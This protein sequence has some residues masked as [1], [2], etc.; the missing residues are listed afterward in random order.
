MKEEQH[1]HQKFAEVET[2]S[3][4]II[5]GQSYTECKETETL[6]QISRC[7]KCKGEFDMVFCIDNGSGEYINLQ[8]PPEAVTNTLQQFRQKEEFK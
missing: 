7:K 4:L 1:N 6:I 8:V 3:T 2:E 5:T